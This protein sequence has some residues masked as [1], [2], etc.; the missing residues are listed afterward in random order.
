[1]KNLMFR[2]A[3]SLTSATGDGAL[4]G[5]DSSG[6]IANEAYKAFKGVIGVVMPLLLAVVLLVGIF[7]GVSLGLK[8]AKAED[9]DARDKAKG[10]LINLVIGVVV[11]AV[12]IAICWILASKTDLFAGLFSE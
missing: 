6:S 3:T 9:T 7:Y 5:V 8:F 10:Q 11:A 4:G 1:M 2:L 12:I